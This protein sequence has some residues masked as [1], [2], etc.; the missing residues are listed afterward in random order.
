MTLE[1]QPFTSYKLEEERAADNRRTFTVS[2]N[3]KEEIWIKE[4]REILNIDSESRALK[5]LAKIGLNVLHNTF[6]A[7]V[8]KY[9]TR[10]NRKRFNDGIVRKR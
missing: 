5:E 1:K 9:L 2:I 7:D 6:G 3:K 4:G 10:E 8:I